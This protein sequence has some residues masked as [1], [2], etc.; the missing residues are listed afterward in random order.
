MGK[1]EIYI[2]KIRLGINK[3]MKNKDILIINNSDLLK[4]VNNEGRKI[5]IYNVRALGKVIPGVKDNNYLCFKRP[6]GFNIGT[7]YL[8]IKKRKVGEHRWN[9]TNKMKKKE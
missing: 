7:T 8:F 2:R 5:K 1:A 4:I 6:G 3:I 9:G